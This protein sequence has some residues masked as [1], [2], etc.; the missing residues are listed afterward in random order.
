MT[1]LGSEDSAMQSS[2]QHGFTLMELL[3]VIA[4]IGLLLALL[5]PAVQAAREAARRSECAN[6]LKQIGVA[7]HQFQTAHRRFPPGWL[8]PKPSALLPPYDGQYAGSLVFVLPYLELNMIS[9]QIDVDM[10]Q[11]G[12]ISII[13]LDRVGTGYWRRA[14][15]WELAQ[16]RIGSFVTVHFPD[17]TENWS[18]LA[19]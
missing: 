18:F 12:N 10:P 5:L 8:G 19:H 1:L 16:T 2:R 14:K 17:R 6:K 9:D 4:I 11:Q 3:V 7:S 15:A 13:D